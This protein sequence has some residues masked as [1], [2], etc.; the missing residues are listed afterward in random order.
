MVARSESERYFFMHI[1]KTAGTALDVSL[2]RLHRA[3]IYPLEANG[4]LES[5]RDYLFAYMDVR[6]L[7]DSFRRFADRIRI[8][9]GHF[10]LCI[11]EIL[12]APLTTFSLLRD[13]V[14]RALSLL[15][16][17][18][19]RNRDYHD[20]PLDEIYE[21]PYL[22]HGTIHNYMVK[23]LSM[24]P[25]EVQA[26]V[27]TRLRCDEDRLERAAHN[28]EHKVALFGVQEDFGSFCQQLSW[29][30]G[31]DLG[32]VANVNRSAPVEASDQLRQRIARDNALDV[33]LYGFA[34]E[35][36]GR[37]ALTAM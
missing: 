19:E 16:R 7:E 11:D 34:R 10:P 17:H 9:T 30:F 27:W 13:P 28:L 37:R 2:R 31:W 22:F 32:D 4:Q 25:A 3:S 8:I 12:G 26:G 15:R 1:P 20:S 14:E 24:S 21:D 36:L 29:H 23:V 5:H 18:K 6:L 35:L 33:E